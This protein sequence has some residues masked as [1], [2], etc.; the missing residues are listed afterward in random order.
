MIPDSGPN[1]DRKFHLF[2][3]HLQ[4]WPQ[5]VYYRQLQAEEFRDFI[6][7]MDIPASEPVFLMGDFNEDLINF[8]EDTNTLI[9]PSYLNATMP[10]II[11]EQLYTSDPRK[12]VLVGRD[13][14][15]D[16][17]KG[18]FEGNWGT[19]DDDY[20]G[21]S[22]N[23]CCFSYY[24]DYSGPNSTLF[25]DNNKICTCYPVEWLDYILSGVG[26]LQPATSSMEAIVNR[27]PV[28]FEIPVTGK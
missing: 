8:P 14:G 3:T 1:K 21:P 10:P 2:A 5:N 12:N 9:G 22:C 28:S 24:Y 4:A 27:K 17:C 23:L 11:G 15:A 20:C 7:D 18:A 16:A 26:N 19:K 6:D 13:G 25:N